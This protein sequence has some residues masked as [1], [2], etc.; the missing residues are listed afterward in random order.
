[1]WGEYDEKLR[2]IGMQAKVLLELHIEK[3]KEFSKKVVIER[4]LEMYEKMDFNPNE[5]YN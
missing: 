5:D 2:E 1:M 3:P 4:L